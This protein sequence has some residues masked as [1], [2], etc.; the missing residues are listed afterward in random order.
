MATD[1]PAI[2]ILLADKQTI[3]REGLRGLLS[4]ESGFAV[5][6]SEADDQAAMQAAVTLQ[7]DILLLDLSMPPASAIEVLRNCAAASR[8]TRTIVLATSE[9]KAW[10]AE[11]FRLG[12]RGAVMKDSGAQL[13]AQAIRSVAAGTYWLLDRAATNLGE[14]LRGLAEPSMKLVSLKG[15]G[16]TPRELEIVSAIVSG[17]SN[18]QIAEQMS[19]SYET[20]K[21]HLTNIYDKLGVFNRLELALF[22]IYHELMDHARPAGEPEKTHS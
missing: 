12:A 18:R 13:L 11:A 6:G 7:P 3:F 22:A 20:I 19:I 1:T 15:F 21:H 2:R 17:C 8:N 16:L 9:Q 5:A 10:I 4:R 14:V